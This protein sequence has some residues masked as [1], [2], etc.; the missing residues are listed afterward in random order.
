MTDKDGNQLPVLHTPAKRLHLEQL[1]E[2]MT[3]Q[4]PVTAEEQEITRILAYSHEIP[5]HGQCIIS[6]HSAGASS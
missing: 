1:F 4:I 3:F 5:A 6:S 2:D